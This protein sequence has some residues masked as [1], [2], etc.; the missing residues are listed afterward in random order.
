MARLAHLAAFDTVKAAFAG[1]FTE[2]TAAHSGQAKPSALNQLKKTSEGELTKRRD[3]PVPSSASG[4]V[5]GIASARV[6][7]CI[8]HIG[9]TVW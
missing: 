4:V 1:L 3:I 6:S 8:L 7:R 9:S 2:E 5:A